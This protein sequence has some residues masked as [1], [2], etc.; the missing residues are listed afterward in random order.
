MHY[1]ACCIYK[2]IAKWTKLHWQSY[3][4]LQPWS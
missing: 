4:C 3:Y 2:N 1:Q